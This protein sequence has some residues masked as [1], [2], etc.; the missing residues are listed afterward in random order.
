MSKRYLTPNSWVV[1]HQKWTTCTSEDVEGIWRSKPKEQPIGLI[2][3]IPVQFPRYTQSFGQDYTFAGQ[4]ATA[5]DLI[6]LPSFLKGV[7]KCIQKRDPNVNGVL[8][9]YYDS[10]LGH[11]IGKH[12]DDEK[13]L[14][15]GS[16]I[17]S[18]TLCNTEDHY[19]RF[20]LTPKKRNRDEEDPNGTTT[21][22]IYALHNG[23]MFEMGGDCQSTHYH[24]I[25][26]ARERDDCESYGRRINVT[27]R[28][29]VV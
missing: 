20:R 18:L 25:M 11:Y 10:E 29:F 5:K 21:Q 27:F 3:G 24:E 19:R 4:T 26:K 14:I 15:K 28:S 1:M 13:Q 16:T 22:L 6:E 12:S 17:Y 9:N 2:M 23:D 8:L 7:L